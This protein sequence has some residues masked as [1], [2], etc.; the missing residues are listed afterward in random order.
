MKFA[1]VFIT[2]SSGRQAERLADMLISKRLAACVNIIKGVDSVFVWHGKRERVKEVL[3]IAK[4]KLSCFS[5][6]K[7]EVKEIHSYQVPEIIALPIVA[8]NKEYLKWIDES[9]K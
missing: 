2:A 5:K 1:V 7:K 3:L 9:V 6:L 8:G 4:I